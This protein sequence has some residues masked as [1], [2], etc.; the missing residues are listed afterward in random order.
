MFVQYARLL[1]GSLNDGRTRHG[2]I[3]WLLAVLLPVILVAAAYIM[4]GKIN[5]LL[6]MAFAIGILFLA[7]HFGQFVS[8]AE[9][10]AA[11]LRDNNL[12]E[13]RRLLEGWQECETHA[14][15]AAQVSRVGIEATLRHAHH[16]LFAPIFWFVLLGPAG[17]LLYR[18]AYLLK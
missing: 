1:E 16:D 12:D 7:L 2:I 9:Q 10:I 14:F 18:L 11:R 6:S 4:L 5:P 17:A 15:S 8:R 13:A 3:A